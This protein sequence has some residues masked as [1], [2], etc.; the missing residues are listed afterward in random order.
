MPPNS[1]HSFYSIHPGLRIGEVTAFNLITGSFGKAVKV[2][3]MTDC[4]IASKRKVFG[5]ES[6]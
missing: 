4:A 2:G 1:L 5:F 6:A 3:S